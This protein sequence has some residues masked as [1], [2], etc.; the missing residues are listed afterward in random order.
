MFP[1][2][3]FFINFFIYLFIRISWNTYI[4]INPICRNEKKSNLNKTNSGRGKDRIQ[5][6]DVFCLWRSSTGQWDSGRDSGVVESITR[7]V[8]CVSGKFNPFSFENSHW[9]F[10]GIA[11]R[12]VASTFAA[13]CSLQAHTH[14]LT[15]THKYVWLCVCVRAALA[16]LS[17]LLFVF[18]WFFSCSAF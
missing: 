10:C 7:K 13:M 12:F 15:H 3:H 17:I 8:L 18:I 4:Y 6:V 11:A 9:S 1:I 16:K 2:I 5:A 14:T